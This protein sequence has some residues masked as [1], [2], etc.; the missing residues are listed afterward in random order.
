VTPNTAVLA[1]TWNDGGM[2]DG[3]LPEILPT[4]AINPRGARCGA[5]R[6][7]GPQMR[8]RHV[9]NIRRRRATNAP[10]GNDKF[11]LDID[12]AFSP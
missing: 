3:E 11:A 4:A 2:A 5:A 6:D 10:A 12:V 1:W 7:Y 9:P 8:A